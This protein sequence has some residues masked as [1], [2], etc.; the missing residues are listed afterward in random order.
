M[1]HETAQAKIR[2]TQKLCPGMLWDQLLPTSITE[3]Y[4]RLLESDLF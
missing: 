2:L 3:L 4:D 1:P